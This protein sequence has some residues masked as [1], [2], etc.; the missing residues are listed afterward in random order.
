MVDKKANK[1][2]AN[3]VDLLLS[4]LLVVG[5]NNIIIIIKKEPQLPLA[6]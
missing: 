4:N 3:K 1:D 5:I 2:I 6:I